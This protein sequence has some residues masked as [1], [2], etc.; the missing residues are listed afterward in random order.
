M[1]TISLSIPE[2][3]P[4]GVELKELNMDQFIAV[5]REIAELDEEKDSHEISLKYLSRMLHVGGQPVGRERLGQMGM[6]TVL[7]LVS[8][9]NDLFPQP[10]DSGKS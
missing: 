7:P 10:D 6:S 8:K 9:V 1:K 2:L 4:K 5:Q 3:A